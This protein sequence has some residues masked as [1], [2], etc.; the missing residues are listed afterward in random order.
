MQ[1]EPEAQP[2]PSTR[3]LLNVEEQRD[4]QDLTN[5][6][7]YTR[8]ILK[9]MSDLHYGVGAQQVHIGEF[10]EYLENTNSGTMEEETLQETQRETRL[11]NL[12][13]ALRGREIE[14]LRLQVSARFKQQC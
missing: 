13:T 10:V 14:K 12:V 3:Q 4:H 1:V 5:S 9:P 7:S 11:L 8:D 6:R 2:D